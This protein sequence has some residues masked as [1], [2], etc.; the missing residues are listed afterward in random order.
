MNNTE[1]II[2]AIGGAIIKNQA[3]ILGCLADD[4]DI[5]TDAVKKIAE[6][7]DTL[8]QLAEQEED[9]EE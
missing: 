8:I 6:L 2:A 4:G 5:I 1:K 7:G 3:L 9:E